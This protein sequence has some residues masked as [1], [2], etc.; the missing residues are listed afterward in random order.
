MGL[1][2]FQRFAGQFVSIATITA[3]E[4]ALSGAS[5]RAG[6]RAR[7]SNCPGVQFMPQDDE[8]QALPDQ[9]RDRGIAAAIM[10]D[11]FGL[12]VEH[13]RHSSPGPTVV[14]G[15]VSNPGHAK[16]LA[17][18]VR[19]EQARL[20][21]SVVQ[22]RCRWRSTRG[23][24]HVTPYSRRISGKDHTDSALCH[25]PAAQHPTARMAL[26]L[27][28]RTYGERAAAITDDRFRRADRWRR[29]HV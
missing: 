18:V 12:A 15:E 14:D 4:L 29:N 16:I 25:A 24:P 3:V 5:Q 6:T 19:V 26:K 10:R 23:F 28:V 20:R 11:L 9:H 21:A 17:L 13:P 8:L 22:R 27:N 2:G 7:G 1:S